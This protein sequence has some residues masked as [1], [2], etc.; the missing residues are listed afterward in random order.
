MECAPDRGTANAPLLS[1]H[2][3]N[4][5]TLLQQ[6]PEVYAQFSGEHT[7]T[8]ELVVSPARRRRPGPKKPVIS[9]KIWKCLN[10]PVVRAGEAF[11]K[12]V[13]ARNVEMEQAA[14]RERM[15]LQ[16][17]E[18]NASRFNTAERAFSR[19][20]LET[21]AGQ[22]RSNRLG[23]S[24]SEGAHRSESMN[25]LAQTSHSSGTCRAEVPPGDLLQSIERYSRNPGSLLHEKKSI[26][27]NG[28]LSRDGGDEKMLPH[29][30]VDNKQRETRRVV[31]G[32]ATD[33]LNYSDGSLLVLL[34][35]KVKSANPALASKPL[36]LRDGTQSTI[37]AR[38]Q[39]RL[40]PPDRPVA[41]SG[42]LIME[43]PRLNTVHTA[44]TPYYEHTMSQSMASGDSGDF[45]HQKSSASL[46]STLSGAA[47]SQSRVFWCLS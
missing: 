10:T 28:F 3:A 30:Q 9:K 4:P 39:P 42:E 14:Q 32:G 41:T 1:H 40:H 46:L 21:R 19:E 37:R 13:V 20:I 15:A 5:K 8:E 38:T 44:H 18:R 33:R 11:S 31:T 26:L 17:Y 6:Y 23:T 34:P 45:F 12:T 43:V 25:S 35:P 7:F 24:Y 27:P 36:V 47:T 29:F 16:L 22:K 2:A